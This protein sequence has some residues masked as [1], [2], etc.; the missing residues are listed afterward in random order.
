[1][2]GKDLIG[3]EYEPLFDYFSKKDDLKNK[4]NGWKIYDADFVS[5]EEG[6]GVVHV[7]PAFGEDDLNLGCLKTFPLFNT[8]MKQ[9]VLLMKLQNGQERK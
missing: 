6:T 1:M 4:E 8:L 9:V 2:K 7:A 3:L 5:T